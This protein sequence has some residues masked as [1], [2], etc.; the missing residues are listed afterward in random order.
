MRLKA[1]EISGFKSFSEKTVLNFTSDVTAIVGPNGCGKSN[2]VDALRWAMGEQSARHLRGQSM[3]DVIFGG[4]ERLA[5]IGMAE[6]TVLLDNADHSAPTDYAAFAEIAVTRRLFRSGESEYFINRVPCRL[7]DIV[8]LFLGSGIG[9]KSYSIIGQGRVEELVNAKPEDRRRVIEEAAG[10]SRFKSRKQAA[11]RRMERTRQNL[12]R[13]NDIVREVEGQLRKIELQAKKAE[14]YRTLKEQLK[15]QELRWAGVRTRHLERE[16]GERGAAI[17]AVEERI[18]SLVAAMQAQ[19]AEGERLRAALQ[20]VEEAAGSLQERLYQARSGLQAEEQR[21]GFFERAEEESRGFAESAREEAVRTSTRLEAVASEID[22]LSKAVEEFSR[23]WRRE[24]DLVERTESETVD[25]RAR[26]G[27]LQAAVERERE[28]RSDRVFEHSRLVNSR[29]SHQERLE[30]LGTESAEKESERLSM[31]QALEALRRQRA[32]EA[33]EL[34]GCLA[35]A[36]A[37]E[38]ALRRADAEMERNR[39]EL[40]ED[41][42]VLGRLKEELQEARSALTSLETL[43]KNFEGYQEGVRA[44]MVKHE[45]NGGSDGVCGVV[46]DFIEAPEEVE[47]ALTAV[48]GE[49]LQYVVVQG[50]REGVEAIEYLKRESAGRGAFIPRRFE[51]P[52][53]AAAPAPA[54][55]DVIAP[56]LGLVR[57]KDGYRDVADYLLGDVSVVRDLESGLGLWHAN[58]F[59]HSLVTLDGEVIDPMGVV[60]GGS[61]ESL[62]GGPLSRRR[63]IKE[64]HEE[65][66]SGED[67]VRRQCEGVAEKRTALEAM[68]AERLRLGQE[69]QG[70]AVKKVQREQELLRTDQAVARS[71]R[72]LTTVVQELRNVAGEVHGLNEAISA[73]ETALAESA[74]EDEA[75]QS[76]L[77]EVQE[78]VQE[79]VE[80]L[81]AA[82]ARLTGCRVSAAEARERAENAK[83][84]LANRVSLRDEL[85][86]Q[87]R[88][89]EARIAE[90]NRKAGEMREARERAASR[91]DV[92][93]VEVDGLEVEVAAKQQDQRELAGRAREAQEAAHRIRPDVDASQQ[94]GNRLQLCERETSMELRH[95]RDDIR[96]KYGVEPQD[97]SVEP[98]DALPSAGDLSEEVSEL[99]ARLQ[100]MGEVNLAAIGE[101]EELTERSQFLTAQREDL[102]RS[103]ADLQQTITKLNRICRLRFKESFEEINR[104]FQAIFPRLFQGGKASLMLTD[105]N[106]YLE[107][108]VDIVAQPPG[109]KLQSVGLLSGG[110]KALTAV[111]L[112]FAIFLTKPSPFCFL[113]EVDAPLDD[114]NLERFIDIVKEMTRL[115]Q[116]MIITHNKQTM[117]AADVLYG[118][119]MEDPGVSKIVSVEMV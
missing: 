17:R 117:Q 13:V 100:R 1:L 12:L 99:R 75:S 101:F 60:T 62:Q 21:I 29:Q 20:E 40:I 9:N 111:S 68:D 78:A 23:V 25:L 113:D 79:S 27:E 11:E 104:E 76:R 54:G 48:L 5:A 96:E 108:G 52:N 47:K 44:V 18:A 38:E 112:L 34:N 45:S 32:C 3:E 6:G 116:F 87:L 98:D 97:S 24:A 46:A 36:A 115:S 56:L 71:E 53:C 49:R 72:D 58:G 103:M 110:E 92:L 70:L 109:K 63:R 42:A 95:L 119:T 35:R 64:L 114:V 80:E 84:N 51:R 10:T 118:V 37:T 81:R 43:Q 74:R 7:R 4:S 2:I 65:V 33:Q 93:R 102:E 19:E 28:G 61:V 90:M 82:D 30:R 69:L 107:T 31:E 22:D 67:E 86:V 105:E 106:D 55:P 16:L 15:E 85:A 39:C 26:I 83:S 14:R 50:H 77:R 94:E 8:D 57:V 73:C 89:R 91:V 59:S 88:E 66:L 41:E